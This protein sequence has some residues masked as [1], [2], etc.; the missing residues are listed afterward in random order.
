MPSMPWISS[1]RK[2]MNGTSPIV[3]GECPCGDAQTCE[4][5]V[6][7]RVQELLNEVE[8]DGQTPVWRLVQNYTSQYTCATYSY[9][10]YAGWERTTP[11]SGSL[12]IAFEDT[13]VGGTSPLVFVSGTLLARIATD[14]LRLVYCACHY[15]PD[16][17][18]C[19]HS[20]WWADGYYVA[21]A[22]AVM[23][24]Y[25]C[26][27]A[28]CEYL[29]LYL[30]AGWRRWGGV[31]EGEGYVE[32]DTTPLE[33]AYKMGWTF[34]WDNGL[35][36]ERFCK[37][38]NCACTS[39]QSLSN[40]DQKN[41][42]LEYR[43]WYVGMT[44]FCTSPCQAALSLINS[45]KFHGQRFWRE[46]CFF[47]RDGH[48]ITAP[49]PDDPDG[50]PIP[51]EYEWGD[52]YNFS[53]DSDYIAWG[54]RDEYWGV[55]VFLACKENGDGSFSF[56]S[57]DCDDI[58]TVDIDR[59]DTMWMGDYPTD[60]KPIILPI[61]YSGACK[62]IDLREIVMAH[63]E[64]FGIV[65][66]SMGS[67]TI[68]QNANEQH[69]KA[70]WDGHWYDTGL[71]PEH[72]C[73]KNGDTS[74]GGTADFLD[75]RSLCVIKDYGWRSVIY[76]LTPDLMESEDIHGSIS[77]ALIQRGIMYV[78]GSET[79]AYSFTGRMDLYTY[80]AAMDI[81][82][83][84]SDFNYDPD[85]PESEFPSYCNTGE[86]PVI[87]AEDGR[88]VVA[89][90]RAMMYSQAWWV[91]QGYYCDC[92]EWTGGGC[93]STAYSPNY[94]WGNPSGGTVPFSSGYGAAGATTN[95]GF[96]LQG[97]GDPVT[98]VTINLCTTGEDYTFAS[99]TPKGDPECTGHKFIPP[100]DE[101]ESEESESEEN[102]SE[103]AL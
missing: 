28:T 9:N 62:C 36:E 26:Q 68:W 75:Y 34:F 31:L 83:Y 57:C 85:D 11:A 93:G 33:G 51:I 79:A 99:I 102:E 97:G 55:P 24:A 32:Y 39:I 4:A 42:A 92:G 6:S 100:E 8:I 19:R 10:P 59:F 52:T 69:K 84:T 87:W 25:D 21:G 12:W 13:P 60:G 29:Q 44:G 40:F 20:Y 30:T 88:H 14:E 82:Y 5:V 64:D 18:V 61:E 35:V 67:N 76:M 38:L 91:N 101:S 49:Y 90:L 54:E 41:S 27:V 71:Q 43:A 1:G 48:L 46:G 70:D 72:V 16:S 65:D 94:E 47:P 96:I 53:N 66:V 89:V 3:C 95:R 17:H 81:Y 77:Q 103:E 7:E 2:L 73:F 45:A 56:V 78:T 63:A 37:A 22:L 58:Y 15:D 74:G 98:E 23:P 86:M 50:P 80:R